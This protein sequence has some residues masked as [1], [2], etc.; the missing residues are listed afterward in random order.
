MTMADHKAAEKAPR[1]PP[2]RWEELCTLFTMWAGTKSLHLLGLNAIRRHILSLA[3][4]KHRYTSTY[5]ANLVWCVLDDA[6]RWLNQVVP[7]NDLVSTDDIMCLQFP[8]TRLHRAA[9]M[10]SMQSKYTMATFPRE[11]QTYAER[12]AGHSH[13]SA[14]ASFGSGASTAGL[15]NSSLSAITGNSRGA[16]SIQSEGNKS[17]ETPGNKNKQHREKHPD[18][19]NKKA[20]NSAVQ[21]DIKETLTGMRNVP[22][23]KILDANNNNYFQLKASSRYSQGIYLAFAT[24]LFTY[25]NCRPAYLLGQETPQ[26]WAK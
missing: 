4:T 2:L 22:F 5:F 15:L 6:V 19:Y 3:E 21:E 1:M 20:V 12:R 23:V 17:K 18:R 9:E 25:E 16:G 13:Y 14:T 10:L 8:T 7:Y 24:G 26:A 11:W